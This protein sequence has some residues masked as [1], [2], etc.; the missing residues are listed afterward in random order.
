MDYRIELD[1]L[2]ARIFVTGCLNCAHC[3]DDGHPHKPERWVCRH[4]SVISDERL[5]YISRNEPTMCGLGAR[6]FRDAITGR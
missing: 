4:Q 1:D 2:E 3:R 5:C 6:W